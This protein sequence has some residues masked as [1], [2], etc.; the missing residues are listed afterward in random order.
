[1]CISKNIYIYIIYIIYIYIIYIIYIYIYIFY[2]MYIFI[3]AKVNHTSSKN[4]G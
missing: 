1:M 3:V 2:D 4:A